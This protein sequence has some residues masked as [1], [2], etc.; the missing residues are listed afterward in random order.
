LL[1][2]LSSPPSPAGFWTI[3]V[4]RVFSSISLTSGLR[5][6]IRLRPEWLQDGHVGDDARWKRD[7]VVEHEYARAPSASRTDDHAR[8]QVAVEMRRAFRRREPDVDVRVAHAPRGFVRHRSV[9][10]ER[11]RDAR[12]EA[13]PR[14]RTDEARGPRERGEE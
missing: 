2:G 8:A 13:A 7:P 14:E 4:T 6:R 3:V 1:R 5:A 12:D 10:L 9:I 11:D